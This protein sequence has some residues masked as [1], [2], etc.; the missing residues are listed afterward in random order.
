[1]SD[2]PRTDADLRVNVDSLGVAFVSPDFARELERENAKLR[3]SA[4]FGLIQ[5]AREDL[6]CENAKLREL[7]GRC[8]SQLVYGSKNPFEPTL[9]ALIDEIDGRKLPTKFPTANSPG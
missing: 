6:E 8:R 5:L 7:L 3:V 4:P 1:M 9:A 2:T